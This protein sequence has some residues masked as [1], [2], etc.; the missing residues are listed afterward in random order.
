MRWVGLGSPCTIYVH[1]EA[2]HQR[3]LPALS[4]LALTPQVEVISLGDYSNELYIVVNG[5]LQ[6]RPR[7][8]LRP[9]SP[10]RPQL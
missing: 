1:Q 7:R 4:T 10:A 3:A 6:A 5:E 9:C 2:P 8:P